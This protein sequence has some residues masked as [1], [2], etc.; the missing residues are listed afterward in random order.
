MKTS[1]QIKNDMAELENLLEQLQSLQHK[2]S[3]PRKCLS[4]INLVLDELITNTIE[5]G[6]SNK[7]YPIHIT[8]TKTGRDL[9]IEIVD[10]GPPFDP[11]INVAPDITL[12]LEQRKCGGLGIYLARQFCDCWNY[13]R[14]PDKNVLTLQK[15]LPKECG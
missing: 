3:L 8:L 10:T 4:E 12:P 14:L 6:D 2:W 9:T 11:T 1:F 5:H 13:S 7:K 15:T